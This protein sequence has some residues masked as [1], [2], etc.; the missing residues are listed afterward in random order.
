MAG[1]LSITVLIQ[2]FL[3][4]KKK[5]RAKDVFKIEMSFNKTVYEARDV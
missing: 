4:K 5:T 3:H 2:I 1:H